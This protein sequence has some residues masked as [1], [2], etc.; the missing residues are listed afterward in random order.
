MT[1]TDVVLDDNVAAEL[2]WVICGEDPP[3]RYR[4]GADI[5]RLF[6]SLGWRVRSGLDGGRLAW[7]RQQVLERS[8]DS[9]AMQALILRLADRREYVGEPDAHMA[10]ITELNRL[11]ALEDLTVTF[12]G[13]RPM[14]VRLEDLPVNRMTSLIPA[15]LT[16]NLTEIVGDEKFADQLNGRLEQ[17]H[18]CWEGGAPTAA[19]I[20]LGS[21]LEGVLYDYLKHHPVEGQRVHDRF[22]LLIDLARE[23]RWISKDVADYAH[24]LRNHRN[25]VHPKRQL[26]DDYRPDPDTVRIA[27]NVVV[28]ALNDLAAVSKKPA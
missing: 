4:T 27:W 23:Q 16:A 14:V 17:A 26:L 28:A 9:D 1:E 3:L 2:A 24:V 13:R 25:L 5:E 19:I 7:T 15:E 6:Q 22:E 12:E 11:L 18:A 20:M 10:T 21:L 8:K